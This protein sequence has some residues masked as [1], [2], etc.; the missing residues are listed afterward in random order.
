[1]RKK[2]LLAVATSEPVAEPQDP[3]FVFGVVAGC[4]GCL[5]LVI[6]LYLS[7][8]KVL[9][10]DLEPSRIGDAKI[11][12]IYCGKILNWTYQQLMTEVLMLLASNR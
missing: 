1:M 10:A 9:A 5:L 11:W 6:C 8:R 2:R 7:L 12:A 3:E 4:F